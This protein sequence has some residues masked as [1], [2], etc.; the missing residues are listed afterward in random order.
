[1]STLQKK[2]RIADFQKEAQNPEAHVNSV[3]NT[4]FYDQKHPFRLLPEDGI[5]QTQSFSA[6]DLKSYHRKTLDGSNMF[7]VYAGPKLDS[8]TLA[9]L[10]AKFGK[11]GKIKREATPVPSP[12]YDK[13][14]SFAFDH[15]PIPT[16]YIR[17][18]FNAPSAISVDAPASDVM[19]EILSQLLHEE[20]RTK[21]SLSYAV[22]AGSI[23]YS[24]GIGMIAASTSKPRE[25]LEAIAS[26]IRKFRDKGVSAE[27]LKEYQNLF[28]TEYYLAMET[29]DHLSAGLAS[30]QAYLGDANRFYELP[31]KLN[32]VT[33][34]DIQR[35]ANEVLKNFRVGVVYDKD[36][37]MS[38]WIDP[39][40]AL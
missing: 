31:A 19:F 30:S 2:Q 27:E 1:M 26:V 9:A 37:F 29:H 32:A 28:T 23:Q 40:K 10:D 24:Q 22:H 6:E 21:R 34:A 3:V 8:K 15:R 7:I 39:I 13:K 11:L 35:V 38:E 36:K 20:V 33:P 5:K 25:T 14:N 18:T 17:I 12:V 4:I 16:A